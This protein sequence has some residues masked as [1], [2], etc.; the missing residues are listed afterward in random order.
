MVVPYK[1]EE[2]CCCCCCCTYGISEPIVWL[3]FQFI[4]HFDFIRGGCLAC[5]S[6]MCCCC[7]EFAGQSRACLLRSSSTAKNSLMSVVVPK[8]LSFFSREFW[9]YF[10]D[11]VLWDSWY[12]THTYWN[13][14]QKVK[15]A[16]SF[17]ATNCTVSKK[18]YNSFENVAMALGM[19]STFS[20][21]KPHQDFSSWTCLFATVGYT[22]TAGGVPTQQRST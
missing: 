1:G 13:N 14:S 21:S 2:V 16:F 17:W 19:Y 4:E 6:C 20:F 5:L 10:R 22:T 8:T 3:L 7:T 18:A 15:S 9:D 11:P 12:T